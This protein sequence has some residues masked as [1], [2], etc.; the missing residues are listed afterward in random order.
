MMTN[1]KYGTNVMNLPVQNK[2]PNLNAKMQN[3][4]LLAAGAGMVHFIN[5]F[6]QPPDIDYM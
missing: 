4:K 3:S 5:T 6:Q 2:P 1:D